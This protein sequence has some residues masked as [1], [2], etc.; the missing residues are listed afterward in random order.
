MEKRIWNHPEM[1][2]QEFVSNEYVAAC[3]KNENNV[4]GYDCIG[5]N[6]FTQNYEWLTDKIFSFADFLSFKNDN[7]YHNHVD[8]HK[9]NNTSNDVFFMTESQYNAVNDAYNSGYWNEEVITDDT[10][11]GQE[12]WALG[13]HAGNS[14]GHHIFDYKTWGFS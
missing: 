8:D 4:D 6:Y 1:E 10:Q 3:T 9:S 5:K 7:T 14:E 13:K 11:I 2:I 12:Y